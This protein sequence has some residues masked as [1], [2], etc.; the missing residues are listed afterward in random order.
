MKR[1]FIFTKLEKT[2]GIILELLVWITRHFKLVK[3]L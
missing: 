2:M 1:R 3:G